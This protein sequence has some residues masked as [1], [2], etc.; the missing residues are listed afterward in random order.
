MLFTINCVCRIENTQLHSLQYCFYFQGEFGCVSVIDDA[1]FSSLGI[2]TAAPTV[3]TT[4]HPLALILEPTRELAVQV[5]N[6]LQAVLKYT[7]IKVIKNKMQK[8]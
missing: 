2:E 8:I 7:D 6:H 5:K 4:Q 1:D 3:L